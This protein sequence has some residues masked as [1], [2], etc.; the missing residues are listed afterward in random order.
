[1]FP[2][3]SVIVR[4][5]IKGA[6]PEAMKLAE[7]LQIYQNIEKNMFKNCTHISVLWFSPTFKITENIIHKWLWRFTLPHIVFTEVRMLTQNSRHYGHNGGM[8]DKVQTYIQYVIYSY[9]DVIF[10][11]NYSRCGPIQAP[12]DPHISSSNYLQKKK[13][14]SHTIIFICEPLWVLLVVVLFI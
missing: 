13:K 12:L 5:S 3:W 11:H 6:I 14:S 7:V 4:C 1:M 10:W 2:D 9:V 8:Y